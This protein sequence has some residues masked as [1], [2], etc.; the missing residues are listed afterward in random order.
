MR[1]SRARKGQRKA[2]DQGPKAWVLHPGLQ[3]GLSCPIC[4]M[5]R[6][7]QRKTPLTRVFQLF[8]SPLLSRPPQVGGGSCSP[9]KPLSTCPHTPT[10]CG[11]CE[12]EQLARCMGVPPG[13][14]SWGNRLERLGGEEF[15]NFLNLDN[16]SSVSQW[17]R[18]KR[19]GTGGRY[20]GAGTGTHVGS[21]ELRPRRVAS[22]Q[23]CCR[24][25]PR[26]ALC[27]QRP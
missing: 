8:C 1:D 24:W 10:P 12:K 22:S 17:G 14:R 5:D 13:G 7:S 21:S 25:G 27:V 2:L 3:L 9:Q 15:G 23:P 11:Q 18:W 20:N 16:W 4:K 6:L 19:L 26:A